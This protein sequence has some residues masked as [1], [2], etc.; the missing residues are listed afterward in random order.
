MRYPVI[1]TDDLPVGV[2]GRQCGPLIFIRPKYRDDE[3]LYRHELEH[4]KQAWTLLLVGHAL[5]TWLYRP[6]RQWAEAQ[7][8]RVQMH[9]SPHLSFDDAARRLASDLYDLGISLDEA[10]TILTREG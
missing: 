7:A 2:G 5:L 3:G 9:Y 4:I 10:K 8:Y 1:Y 6:Y